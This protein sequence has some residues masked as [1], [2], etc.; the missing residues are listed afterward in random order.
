MLTL[1][2]VVKAME[3]RG[4]RVWMRLLGSVGSRSCLCNCCGRTVAGFYRY[5]GRAFGCPYCKSSTRE[6]F[7]MYCLEAGV[8]TPPDVLGRMLHVAPSERSLIK[9]FGHQSGYHP[10]DLFPKLY[11]LAATERMDLMALVS[12]QEYSLVYLSHVMEHVPDDVLV[13]RNLY[14]ALKPGGEAWF[15][16]PLTGSPTRDGTPA[17]TAL[18]REREFGQW[19]HARQYGPDFQQR[20]EGVGFAVHVIRP[21]QL[22]H[23]DIQQYGLDVA[24]WIFVARKRQ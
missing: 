1:K 11:P 12:E 8:L 6:R 2:R 5:G 23:K 24:D 3:A 22:A 18:E 14:R 7:V 10:V 19:D 17:M 9:R 13:L 4:S 21:D 20:L 15:L 16:V